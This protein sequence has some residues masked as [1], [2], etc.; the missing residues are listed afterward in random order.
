MCARPRNTPPAMWRVR[1]TRRSG[2]LE[3]KLPG[4]VKNKALPVILV[5]ASGAR[6]SR[7]VAIAKKLGYEQAHSLSGG[8]RRV[9]RRQPAG[10]KSLN[11]GNRH[12]NRQDVHHRRLPLLHSRQAD[13]EVEGGRADRGNPR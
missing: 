11:P 10:R 2:E 4:M 7:A 8:M 1:S 3:Q 13:P 6:S 9:E 5:C 12:A